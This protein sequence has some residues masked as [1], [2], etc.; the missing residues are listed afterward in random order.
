[1]DIP[2]IANEKLKK[3][4][5]AKKADAAVYRSLV[6]FGA[7][8][9]VLRYLQGTLDYGILYKTT[10]NSRLIGY[11]DSDW[12]GC[13]D[14]MRNTS[15]YVFSIG[16]G[17]CSWVSKKQKAVAQSTAEAE[18]VAAAKATSQAIWLRRIL[19]DMGE[20]QEGGTIL[21]CDNKLAIAIG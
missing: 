4:D 15:G 16:S 9:R 20:K 8:K 1:M 11:F 19:E 3:E 7:A 13:L 18:Y 14:D 12:G 6:H 10:E 5:G 17:I 2:L 21:Y